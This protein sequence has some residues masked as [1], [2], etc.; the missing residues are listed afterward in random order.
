MHHRREKMVESI[1]SFTPITES[2]YFSE[3][4]A[5]CFFPCNIVDIS[6]DILF[7]FTASYKI[8]EADV[9]SAVQGRVT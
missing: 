4:V 3:H 1:W 9:S 2:S 8:L 5:I 7:H 6:M